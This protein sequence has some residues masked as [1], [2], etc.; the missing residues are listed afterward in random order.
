VSETLNSLKYEEGRSRKYDAEVRVRRTSDF[1]LQT[2][3]FRLRTSDLL[4]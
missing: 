3:Y 2:S 4:V 1:V